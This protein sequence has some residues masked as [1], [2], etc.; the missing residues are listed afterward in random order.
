MKPLIFVTGMMKTGT[1][2][3]GGLL[4]GVDDICFYP[5]EPGFNYFFAKN[6]NV[7]DLVKNNYLAVSAISYANSKDRGKEVIRGLDNSKTEQV[8]DINKFG[9]MCEELYGNFQY[10]RTSSYENL[11]GVLNA[12]GKSHIKRLDWDYFGYKSPGFFMDPGYR[13]E[14][15]HIISNKCNRII[16]ILRTPSSILAS[17]YS[18][19]ERVHGHYI[20]REFIANIKFFIKSIYSMI[21][22]MI[23]QRIFM[24]S[25]SKQ[26][27]AIE[28]VAL[29][30]DPRREL[31]RLSRLLECSTI[32]PRTTKLKFD[33][34][35][36]TAVESSPTGKIYQSSKSASNDFRWSVWENLFLA[37]VDKIYLLLFGSYLKCQKS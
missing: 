33:H 36:I 23:W 14:C 8:I 20:R 26:V 12:W 5:E 37:V 29:T 27:I 24:S 10:N 22:T 11:Y 16:F 18:H 6:K 30:V 1:T 3:L 21:G 28:Y 2:M 32:K 9:K 34:S 25:Y 13:E 19:N 15:E 7:D 35:P 4:D 17:L 31:D